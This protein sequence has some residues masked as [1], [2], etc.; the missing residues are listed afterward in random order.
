MLSFLFSDS[1]PLLYHQTREKQTIFTLFFALLNEFYRR[2]GQKRPQL[3][4]ERPREAHGEFVALAA[5]QH[6]GRRFARI[7]REGIEELFEVLLCPRPARALVPL[8]ARGLLGRPSTLPL[9]SALPRGASLPR[10]NELF[11]HLIR[12]DDGERLSGRVRSVCPSPSRRRPL[13]GSGARVVDARGRRSAVD[14][15]VQ[16]FDGDERHRR[17]RAGVDLLDACDE[18]AEDDLLARSRSGAYRLISPVSSSSS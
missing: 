11:R 6:F 4:H 18:P 12:D 3:R 8:S 17:A 2:F 1:P 13:S 5:V 10:G 16:V 7:A 15:P 14:V 9:L